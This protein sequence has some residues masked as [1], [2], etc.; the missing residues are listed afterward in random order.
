MLAWIKT[1]LREL[2]VDQFIIKVMKHS[3]EWLKILLQIIIHK[4][5]SV[6]FN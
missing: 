4:C 1:P 2:N 5:S 6:L 3:N